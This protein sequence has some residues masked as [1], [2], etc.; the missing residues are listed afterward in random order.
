MSGQTRSSCSAGDSHSRL[1]T[2]LLVWLSSG[3]R[4]AGHRDVDRPSLRTSVVLVK[5]HHAADVDLAGFA[6]DDAI[7]QAQVDVTVHVGQAAPTDVMFRA[8]IEVPSGILTLGDPDHED[9]LAVEPGRSS[10]QVNCTPPDDAADTVS[11]WL[12]RA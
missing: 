5:V 3:L 8:S 9:R 2:G 4:P 11:V 12:Q 1:P 10:V 7:P 6:G